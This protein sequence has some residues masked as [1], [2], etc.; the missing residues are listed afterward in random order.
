M[1]NP[2]VVT[3]ALLSCL[4]TFLPVFAPAGGLMLSMLAPFPLIVLGVKYPW[5]CVLSVLGVETVALLAIEG[6]ST[7]FVLTY[8]AVVPLLM[9]AAVRRG[10]TM[11]QTIVWSVCVPTVLSLFVLGMYSLM[12][13]KSPSALLTQYIE[14]A[15]QGGVEPAKPPPSAQELAPESELP[16]PPTPAEDGLD[17]QDVRSIAQVLPRLVLTLLPALLVVN[18][19][20]TNVVN[21][22]VVYWYCKRSRPP[23]HIHTEALA[24]WRVSDYLV[25]VF[26]ASGVLLLLPLG[27]LSHVGLNVFVVTLALYLLQGVAI[28]AFW[29]LRLPIP[30]GARLLLAL[31]VLLFVGPL[32]LVL[33]IAAGLFDLWVDFRRQRHHP[34]VS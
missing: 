12:Q 5:S 10:M 32:F 8:Y 9:A 2:E 3:L 34:L 24:S 33:C 17:P 30:P 13:Q 11:S 20:L 31:L 18:Y 28:A 15:L 4:L 29:G 23:L 25:W 22:G 6:P 7:W 27:I 26:L 19:L 16:L 1:R 14:Q 21:Y